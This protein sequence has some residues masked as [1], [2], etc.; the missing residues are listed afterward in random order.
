VYCLFYVASFRIIPDEKFTH[1]INIL[2]RTTESTCL[3]EIHIEPTKICIFLVKA[4]G[5]YC[6]HDSAIF[7]FLLVT[8]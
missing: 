1:K 4:F 6:L 5:K 3:Q 8:V 2:Q 7:S